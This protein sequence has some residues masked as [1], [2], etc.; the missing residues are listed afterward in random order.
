M[1]AVVAS[2]IQSFRRPTADGVITSY[3]HHNSKLAVLV[4]INCET[5]FLART[6]E[7]A[8][9]ANQIAEH[10]A[11]AAPVVVDRAALPAE[12]VERKRRQFQDAVRASGKPDSL[13]ARIVD[14]KMAAYFRDVALME[15]R[16]VREPTMTIG[17]LVKAVSAR[18]GE[19]I[20]VRRFARFH[21]GIA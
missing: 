19:N 18:T 12:L 20:Q 7:F 11:G 16:W 13:A 17:D 21:M 9:L 8:V 4:E 15:Q 14:G 3:I 10:I 1:S 2:H 6:E 5:D